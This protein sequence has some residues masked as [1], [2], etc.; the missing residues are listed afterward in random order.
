[1]ARKAPSRR[2]PLRVDP[3]RLSTLRRAVWQALSRRY[4]ALAEA[5]RELLVSRDA[6]GLAPVGS[7]RT[8]L[9]G[10]ATW[11]FDTNPNKVKR[12][13]EWLRKKMDS[14][15]PG[16][17]LLEEWLKRGHGRGAS[18]AYDDLRRVVPADERG[19]LL[20]QDSRERFIQRM[21]VHKPTV[22]KVKL[23]A[24]RTFSDLEG[25]NARMASVMSR[26]LAE[27]LAR[28][29][30]PDVIAARMVEQTR[31][32]AP[33]AM[34]IVQTELVRAHAEGQL[35]A[36]ADQG[37]STVT[38]QVEFA[39]AHDTAVCERCSGLAG[40]VYSLEEARDVIPVHPRCRCAWV[41]V[42]PARRKRG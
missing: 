15:L 13:R 17:D 7:T 6:L 36:M 42:K 32:A 5:I 3:T 28:G 14:T 23:L 2:S 22:E 11:K 25:V 35:D 38:A 10:N 30:P 26:L 4:R 31:L 1:M 33:R 20:E 12:F 34:T 18:R 9:T 21:G 24:G 8:P 29:W 16:D 41:P 37:Q 27:G 19:A 39:T 40:R